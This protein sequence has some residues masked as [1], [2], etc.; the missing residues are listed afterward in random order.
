MFLALRTVY[1]LLA[2][3]LLKLQFV[4]KARRLRN[5]VAVAKNLLNLS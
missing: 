4:T 2:W 5:L 1:R 3:P